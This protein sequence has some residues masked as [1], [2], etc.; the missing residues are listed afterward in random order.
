MLFLIFQNA[1]FRNNDPFHKDIFFLNNVSLL[2]GWTFTSFET[3]KITLSWNVVLRYLIK[4]VI[5]LT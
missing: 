2:V 4:K 3:Q 5:V 1:I